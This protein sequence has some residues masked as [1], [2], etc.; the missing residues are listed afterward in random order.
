MGMDSCL[1]PN[2]I[3]V[4]DLAT[5]TETDSFQLTQYL[6]SPGVLERPRHPYS[7]SS[8]FDEGQIALR[9]GQ[10]MLI[11]SSPTRL[12]DTRKDIE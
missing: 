1:S 9:C 3:E 5:P 8:R 6:I 12:A 7:N 11:V 2:H 10:Y 4:R